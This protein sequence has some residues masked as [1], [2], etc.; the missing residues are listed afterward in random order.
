[1]GAFIL[2]FHRHRRQGSQVPI[3]GRK[4]SDDMEFI[5]ISKSILQHQIQYQEGISK[6]EFRV[7]DFFDYL[8]Q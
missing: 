3:W 6:V 4:E 5:V 7:K 2:L 1:M 8:V